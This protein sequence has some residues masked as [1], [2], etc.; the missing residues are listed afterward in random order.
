MMDTLHITNTSKHDGH[1]THHKCIKTWWTRYTSQK[2]QNMM[3][4][5]HITSASKRDGHATHQNIMDTLHITNTSKHD[6]HATHHK[7]IKTWWTHYTSQTHQNMMDTSQ[8]HQNI[9]RRGEIPHIQPRQTKPTLKWHKHQ[10]FDTILAQNQRRRPLNTQHNPLHCTTPRRQQS[11][12][13]TGTPLRYSKTWWRPTQVE[14][15]CAKNHL[16]LLLQL[17]YLCVIIKYCWTR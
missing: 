7:H 2:Q 12:I 1:A 6:G 4:T 11:C 8:T 14:T 15:C 16:F 5:L 13:E 9:R 17:L 3:D 10:I